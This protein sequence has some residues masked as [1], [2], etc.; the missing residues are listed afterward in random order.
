MSSKTFLNLGLALGLVLAP[1]ASPTFTAFAGPTINLNSL[2]TAELKEEAKAATAELQD[3]LTQTSQ[4]T[5][6]NATRIRAAF[7]KAFA[8]IHSTFISQSMDD[9]AKLKIVT[10]LLETIGTSYGQ[11]AD[12][13]TDMDTGDRADTLGERIRNWGMTMG[14]FVLRQAGFWFASWFQKGSETPV[15]TLRRASIGKEVFNEIGKSL[16]GLSSLDSG[17]AMSSRN[18]LLAAYVGVIE[19]GMQSEPYRYRKVTKTFMLSVVSVAAFYALMPREVQQALPFLPPVDFFPP[20]TFMDRS[21]G[22]VLVARGLWTLYGA[23]G[24]LL[25]RIVT[26]YNLGASIEKTRLEFEAIK[27]KHGI[28]D[29]SLDCNPKLRKRAG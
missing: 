23:A 17:T 3:A 18:D 16:Q 21:F 15:E 19:R 12:P 9:A 13:F 25:P 29:A 4:M 6:A 5:G 14:T 2:S 11:L 10:P 22:S 1:V 24:Y 27:K 28:T 8:I 7:T 20:F 26:G